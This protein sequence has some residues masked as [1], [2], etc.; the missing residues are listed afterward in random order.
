MHSIFA[1]NKFMTTKIVD[2]QMVLTQET[3][4]T[5]GINLKH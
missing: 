3:L 5:V 1:D 2:K 4:M